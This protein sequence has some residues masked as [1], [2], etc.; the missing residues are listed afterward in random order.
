MKYIIIPSIIAQ[1]Q[2]ELER[3]I[4]KITPLKPELVQLD[5]MDGEFV[6]HTS[7]EFDFKIPKSFKLEGHLMLLDPHGWFMKYHAKISS[8][9]VHYESNAHV[10]DMIKLAKKYRKKVGLAVNPE[11][12]VE[13]IAQYLG[14]IDKVLVMSVHPG[15]YGASFLPQVL[16][17]IKHL[18]NLAPKLDIEVDGGITPETLRLCKE[19]GANQFIVGSFLQNAKDVKRAWKELKKALI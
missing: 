11:T 8:V 7:L 9:I 18:R 19:A 16:S 17:K 13:N 14:F 2:T 1:S 4:R 3:R 15:K 10:H 6:K 5:V 12:N